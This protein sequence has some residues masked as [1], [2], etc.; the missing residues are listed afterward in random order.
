MSS[1]RGG[2]VAPNINAEREI[3]RERERVCVCMC[4]KKVHL[5]RNLYGNVHVLVGGAAL[6]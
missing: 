4:E 1:S 5:E 2:G 6:T 3:E